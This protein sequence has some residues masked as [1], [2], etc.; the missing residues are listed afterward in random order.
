MLNTQS[1][2]RSFRSFCEN[3]GLSPMLYKFLDNDGNVKQQYV[4][5]D[6]G[7]EHD[8]KQAMALPQMEQARANSLQWSA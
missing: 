5:M 6:N 2:R 3:S 1:L 7:I 8:H 4:T